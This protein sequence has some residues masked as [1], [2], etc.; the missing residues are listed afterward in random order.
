M[1]RFDARQDEAGTTKILEALHRFDEPFDRLVVLLN[2]VV[3]LLNLPDLDGRFP[4]SIDALEG[5]QIGAAFIHGEIFFIPGFRNFIHR[6][7]SQR[8]SATEPFCITTRKGSFM[9]KA[10]RVL[11]DSVPALR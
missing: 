7:L 10:I 3:Q 4:L 8:L 5:S 6:T 9:S 2:N 1:H 11:T